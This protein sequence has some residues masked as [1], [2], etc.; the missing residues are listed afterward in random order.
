MR[1]EVNNGKTVLGHLSLS[2][3]LSFYPL[4]LPYLLLLFIKNLKG[5]R[6]NVEQATPTTEKSFARITP[7]VFENRTNWHNNSAK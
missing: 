4:F 3:S 5:K 7:T 2:P 1:Q 6:L